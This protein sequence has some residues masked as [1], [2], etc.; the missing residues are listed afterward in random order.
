[1]ILPKRLLFRVA[2]GLVLLIITWLAVTP[3]TPIV[4]GLMWDKGNHVFAFLVLAFLTDFSFPRLGWINWLG[5]TGYGIALECLQWSLDYRYFELNDVF[6]DILGI[7]LYVTVSPLNKRIQFLR[8]LR[9][10]E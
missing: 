7:A 10:G 5:L 4:A 2:L 9:T 3:S 6:A 8:E 1:M